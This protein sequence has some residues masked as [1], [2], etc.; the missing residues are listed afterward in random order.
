MPDSEKLY[1][2]IIIGAGFAG[3]SAA[4]QLARARKQICIIDAGRPRNRFAAASHGFFGLD[5]KSPDEISRLAIGQIRA[6]PTVS[7]VHGMAKAASRLEPDTAGTGNEDN[8]RFKVSLDDGRRFQARRLILA[9]GVVDTLPDIPGLMPRWGK[10][11]L[12]CPYCHGY[13]VRDHDLGVLA[14][15]PMST[16]QAMM[17]S[18]W[19]PTTFFTQGKYEPEPEMLTQ[20]NARRITIERNPIVKLI[21]TAPSLDA[22]KLADGRTMTIQALFA[23]PTVSMTNPLAE[24]LGCAFEE[25][26]AGP[27][28][29]V[30]A[31]QETSIPG[32]FAAG[33]AATARH[34]ATLASAAGVLAGVG[35][36]QSLI[37]S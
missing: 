7:I 19:G 34:N 36:H 16:H 29:K 2:V 32:V 1:D 5:G 10:T 14:T 3:L 26:F 27:F 28:I 15:G 8:N 6:Y 11:V 25:G 23:G 18:D 24:M 21:G 17:I 37:F 20:M 12:H 22:V 13:E 33:D 4:M 35:A 30:D 9:T 31:S